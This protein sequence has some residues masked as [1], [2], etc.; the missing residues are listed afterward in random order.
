MEDH[1]ILSA[2]YQLRRELTREPTAV[3]L[4]C[5]QRIIAAL[6]GLINWLMEKVRAGTRAPQN[7]YHNFT[8]AGRHQLCLFIAAVYYKHKGRKKLFEDHSN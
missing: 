6:T 4:I 2:L 1:E 8:M 5:V 7:C 3:T